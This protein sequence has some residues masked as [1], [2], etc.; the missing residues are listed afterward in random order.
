MGF[1]EGN[2]FPGMEKQLRELCA[3]KCQHDFG[4]PELA[5]HQHP[6]NFPLRLIHQANSRTKRCCLPPALRGISLTFL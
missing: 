4:W 3:L 5:F 6:E 1:V 2:I